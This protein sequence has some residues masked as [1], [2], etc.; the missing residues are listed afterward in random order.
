MKLAVEQGK[1][2]AFIGLAAA[3]LMA[4]GVVVWRGNELA[5]RQNP[6]ARVAEI[7]K[8]GVNLSRSL[9]TPEENVLLVEHINGRKDKFLSGSDATAQ[10]LMDM[11]RRV[12]D[13]RDDD[14]ALALFA[15]VD[16][17]NPRDQFYKID[18]GNIYLER[19]QWEDARQVFEPLRTTLPIHETFIGL[20]EAYKHIEETPDYVIAEIYQEGEWRTMK[21]EVYEEHVEWLEKNGRE[22]ETIPLYET[23]NEIA[24]QPILEDKIQGLKAKYAK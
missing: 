2:F 21:F 5:N 20:A 18:V 7:M 8:N 19:Q 24:P 9:F 13:L 23:M 17:M 22:A 10:N 1:L 14:K 16:S 12:R 6:Q 15:V 11:A 4:V 3:A